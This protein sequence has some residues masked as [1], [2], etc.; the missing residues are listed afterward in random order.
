MSQ[1]YYPQHK[2]ARLTEDFRVAYDHIY[3]IQD[4]LAGMKATPAKAA[5]PAANPGGP[6]TT[7]IAGLNVHATPPM[8]GTSVATLSKIPTLGYNSKTGEIEWFI[9]A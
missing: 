5:A 1:R 9:P 2:D 3:Q 6:S 7:K 8:S 4:Q